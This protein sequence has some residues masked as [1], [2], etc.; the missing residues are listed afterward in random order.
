MKL[1]T[2]QAPI[3]LRVLVVDDEPAVREAT[4]ACLLERGWGATAVTDGKTALEA[5]A[6]ECF[7]LIL[8]DVQMPGMDGFE[9]TR[10]IR[11]LEAKTGGHVPIIGHTAHGHK[12]GVE[13]FSVAGMDDWIA[14]PVA[15]QDLYSVIERWHSTGLRPPL[16]D[17]AQKI[18]SDMMDRKRKKRE[19]VVTLISSMSEGHKEACKSFSEG[20]C[21][22]VEFW[23]H[24]MAGALAVFGFDRARDIARQIEALAAGSRLD[25]VGEL[26]GGLNEELEAI[27]I[28]LAENNS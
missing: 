12:T 15:A 1:D 19:L 9:T 13:K 18:L 21:E 11:E 22:Q 5:H 28:S 10:R 25:G 6:R 26:L 27:K 23:S 8:M 20:D 24:R 16:Q 17:S 7:D 4:A 3:G 2:S 14:K